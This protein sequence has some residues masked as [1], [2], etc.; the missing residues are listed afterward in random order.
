[1][2]HGLAAVVAAALASWVKDLL[3]L[4]GAPTTRQP[5]AALA[6]LVAVMAASA[7]ILQRADTAAVVQAMA[8]AAAT[9]VEMA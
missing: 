8:V 2:A 5:G 1:M 3:E 9:A 4:V 6:A 7:L